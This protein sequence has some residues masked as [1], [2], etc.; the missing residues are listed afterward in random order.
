MKKTFVLTHPK[1]KVPRLFEAAKSDVKKY[2]KRERNKKLPSGAD[3]WDFDC[4]FGKTEAEAED[5]MIS[6]INAQISEVEAQG[7]ASFYLEIIA[8]PAQ[9][10]PRKLVESE[11]DDE[12]LN[13]EGDEDLDELNDEE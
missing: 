10:P 2:F 12:L 13:D 4:R 11:F 7:L 5:V 3:F 8:R 1:I 9:R 6:E